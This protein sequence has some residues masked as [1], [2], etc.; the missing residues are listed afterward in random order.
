MKK[1]TTIPPLECLNRTAAENILHTKPGVTS[2]A[3]QRISKIRDTFVVLYGIHE[4][5]VKGYNSLQQF[6][7]KCCFQKFSSYRCY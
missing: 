3:I 1:W 2:Y 4:S 6:T 5:Y 7:R